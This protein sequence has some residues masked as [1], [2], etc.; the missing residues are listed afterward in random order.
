MK[1]VAAVPNYNM[2]KSLSLLLKSLANERINKIYV[3]DDA[4]TD[5]SADLVEQSV[6]GVV[7]I[8]GDK[9]VG[10]GANRNRL[11]P[12]LSGDELVLFMD[13]DLELRSKDLTDK[14]VT[15]FVDPLTALTGGLILAATGKPMFWNYGSMMNPIHDGRVQVYQEVAKVARQDSRAIKR[16]REMALELQD[17]YNFEIQYAQPIRRKV[18]WVA[19]GLFA[20][21]ANVFQELGGFDE[22]F[23]YHADQDLGL[24]I[25]EAGYRVMFDPGISARHLEVDVRGDAR[26]DEFRKG[27]YLY[28]KKH[29][30]MS[31]NV[32][33]RLF[34]TV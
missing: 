26:W 27:Q 28:Y 18:D 14:V 3:L 7:V 32:F 29:W 31:R 33:E 13:A 4:S 16:V 9:N 21:R 22:K 6:P 19:E 12:L 8:R 2:R 34:P 20:I 24:R 17:T 10:A 5:G 25:A 1:V 23:R 11:L 30:G 15:W